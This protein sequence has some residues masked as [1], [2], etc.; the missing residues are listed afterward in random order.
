MGSPYQPELI[1]TARDMNEVQKLID[2]GVDA[3]TIGHQNYGLRVTG[4]F[5]IEEIKA[6][7]T[8]CHQHGVK[9]YIL[10][11]AIFH[12]DILETIPTYLK[13]LESVKVDGIIC[14][15][16]SIFMIVSSYDIHIPIIWNP[17]TLATNYET[18][19][20]WHQKGI[21]RAILSNELAID[22][23]KEINEQVS[24]PVDIQVHGMTCIFQSKRKLV[25]NYYR[26]I[27]K[28]YDRQQV[29]HITQGKEEDTHYPIFEDVNGTHIMSDADLCM[30]DHLPLLLDAKIHGLRING[31]LKSTDYHVE[32]TQLYKEAIDTYLEDPTQFELKKAGFKQRIYN[33]QPEDRKLGTGFYFKE[34]IY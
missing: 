11:N 9:V 2:V 12:N 28:S 22:A 16:P 20:Y 17:E 33:I 3:I 21:S 1:A 27:D 29:M 31:I 13:E 18:L 32:I 15:D 19:N 25:E 34:Q 26:H 4:D 5:S 23:I 14:G 30:I 24:F 8:Y 6:A 10:T 7:T